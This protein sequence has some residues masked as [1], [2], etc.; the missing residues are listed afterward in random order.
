MV[1]V[2]SYQVRFAIAPC[3][4]VIRAWSFAYRQARKSYWEQVGRDRVR[5]AER[6]RRIEETLAP[7]LS[8]KHRQRVLIDRRRIEAA[9]AARVAVDAM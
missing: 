7:V 5:F 6:C 9:H 2:F 1:S 4:H 3:V 8:A